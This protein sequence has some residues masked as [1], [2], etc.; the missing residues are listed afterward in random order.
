MFEI[1]RRWTSFNGDATAGGALMQ[2]TLGAMMISFSAVWVKLAHVTP[3]ASAFYRVFLGGVFLLI[4]M[5]S[6]REKLWRGS[7]FLGTALLTGGIFSLNL[8]FWHRSIAYVGPG[9]AT[10]L[11]NF[12]V[13]LVPLAG[14][15]IYGERPTLRFV[16]AVPPAVVGLFMIVGV[17]WNQLPADFQ[18]GIFYGLLSATFYTGFLISMR[19]LQA[20]SAA[21]SSAASN[22]MGV[23]FATALFLALEMLRNQESFAVPDMQSGVSLVALAL[24]SQTLAWLMITRSLP[25][26]PAAVAGLLLL[27]QPALSFVWDVLFFH[28]PTDAMAWGGVGLALTAIYLGATSR[29]KQLKPH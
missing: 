13:I 4:I 23:S 3:T 20:G 17:P 19:R 28:R 9:L 24:M 2:T 1:S 8:Y 25:R 14:L 22:L 10:I 5:I 26:I 27:L 15:V 7:A 16:L 29:K 21:A 6:R 12:Q 18:Q 11:S